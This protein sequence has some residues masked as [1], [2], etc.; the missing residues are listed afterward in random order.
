MVGILLI[1]C[2]LNAGMSYWK[3]RRRSNLGEQVHQVR[4]PP[5][6]ELVHRL[7]LASPATIPV[8]EVV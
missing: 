3:D 7:G 2:S 1:S 5:G 8:S 6:I 4:D